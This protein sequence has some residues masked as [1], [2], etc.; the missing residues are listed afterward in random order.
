MKV[1]LA[2][3]IVPLTGLLVVL[4]TGWTVP[5]WGTL[6]S[7]FFTSPEKI[8]DNCSTFS[9]SRIKSIYKYKGSKKYKGNV[10]AKV[11]I[12]GMMLVIS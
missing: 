11:D 3:L 9:I 6:S 8:V 4:L 12:L 2:L 1:F 10:G 7:N 5:A